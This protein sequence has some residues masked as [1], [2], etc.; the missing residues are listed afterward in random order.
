MRPLFGESQGVHS[1]RSPFWAIALG[2]CPA[3]KP[4]ILTSGTTPLILRQ[5]PYMLPP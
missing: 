1:R 2:T 5:R 3:S 4:R